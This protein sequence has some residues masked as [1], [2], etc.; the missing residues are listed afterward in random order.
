[1]HKRIYLLTPWSTVLLEKLTGSHSKV[2][3]TCPFPEPAR[4]SPYPYI[5]IPENTSL[6]YHPIHAWF[7][8]VVSFLQVSPPKHCARLWSSL[9][10]LHAPPCP[11]HSSRFY[12]PN[13][14]GRGVQIVEL[15]MNI[16]QTFYVTSNCDMISS[17]TCY[18]ENTSSIFKTQVNSIVKMAAPCFSNIMITIY[19]TKKY[20]DA[21][22]KTIKIVTSYRSSI[23][24][25]TQNSRV[26]L[27]A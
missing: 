7:L 13:N 25:T 5:P 27:F 26:F 11:S 18:G 9:Y 6:Y 21:G 4:F 2:P 15:P 24:L 10:V 20:H 3:A 16:I 14:I 17:R 8:Q 22:D 19:L 1:M 23:K 12:H